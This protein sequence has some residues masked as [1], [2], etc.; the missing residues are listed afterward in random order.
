MNISYIRLILTSGGE[1]SSYA[2]WLGFIRINGEVRSVLCV[3]DKND[4]F[5]SELGLFAQ[6]L[7]TKSMNYKKTIKVALKLLRILRICVRFFVNF[8]PD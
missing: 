2:Q 5:S 4:C 3:I 6:H 8:H 1:G 7:I